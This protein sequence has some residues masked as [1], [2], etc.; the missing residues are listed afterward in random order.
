MS[1]IDDINAAYEGQGG[2]KVEAVPFRPSWWNSGDHSKAEVATMVGRAV[3]TAWEMSANHELPVGKVEV[4]R[5]GFVFHVVRNHVER[6]DGKM[7]PPVDVDK[8][9]GVLRGRIEALGRFHGQRA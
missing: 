9:L 2:G 8:Q 3:S 5:V 6:Y 7:H 4:N 1:D